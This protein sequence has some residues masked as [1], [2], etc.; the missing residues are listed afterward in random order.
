MATRPIVL[1]VGGVAVERSD[2]CGVV[3]DDDAADHFGDVSDLRVALAV[4]KHVATDAEPVAITGR[5]VATARDRLA[6]QPVAVDVIPDAGVG[7]ELLASV[8]GALPPAADECVRGAHVDPVVDRAAELG[9]TVRTESSDAV[10]WTNDRRERGLR[11]QKEAE[12]R[13]NER[14]ADGRGAYEEAAPRRS[15]LELGREALDDAVQATGFGRRRGRVGGARAPRRAPRRWLRRRG[16]P[17]CRRV[18]AGTFRPGRGARRRNIPRV[19]RSVRRAGVSAPEQPSP[20]TRTSACFHG[21]AGRA[22]GPRTRGTERRRSVRPVRAERPSARRRHLH[23][24]HRAH[25][26]YRRRQVELDEC[27]RR[28]PWTAKLRERRRDEEP[29][30][31]EIWGQQRRRHGWTVMLIAVV[32]LRPRLSLTVMVTV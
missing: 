6:W 16:R 11:P 30:S 20:G 18:V 9:P 3:A 12:R 26:E 15:L 22:R 17:R 31:G 1:L 14:R 28:R 7:T 21:R 24:R 25:E 10:R 8:V 23:Q 29:G 2:R 19:R 13:D 32:A 5:A 4:A 27:V